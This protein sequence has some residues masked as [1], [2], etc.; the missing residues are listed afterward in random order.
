MVVLKVAVA[1]V[2]QAGERQL[3][4]RLYQPVEHAALGPTANQLHR[5]TA[6]CLN[7]RCRGKRSC[8]TPK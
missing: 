1:M 6:S 3:H 2:M 5:T 7:K 4:F 8:E